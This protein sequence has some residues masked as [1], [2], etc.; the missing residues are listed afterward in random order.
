MSAAA[1]WGDEVLVR[2]VLETCWVTA[3]LALPALAEAAKSGHEPVVAALI[4]AGA[5]GTH[6]VSDAARGKS[7]LHFAW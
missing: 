6:P 5:D 2:T 3:A 1:A 4:A 7:A